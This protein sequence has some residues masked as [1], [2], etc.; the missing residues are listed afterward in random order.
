MSWL[1]VEKAKINILM[2]WEQIL[3]LIAPYKDCIKMK[4]VHLLQIFLSI[5]RP[6]VIPKAVERE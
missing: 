5:I 3:A 4:L 1:I 6:C 2:E